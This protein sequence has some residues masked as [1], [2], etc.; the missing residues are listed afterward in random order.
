MYCP[1]C[2][3]QN[4]DGSQFCSN[5]GETT[6]FQGSQ[7]HGAHKRT[8]RSSR[9]RMLF[10]I[11][12]IALVILA[13]PMILLLNSISGSSS[14]SSASTLR[15]VTEIPDP[16]HFFG[17]DC[18]VQE[19]S[20]DNGTI[21]YTITSDEDHIQILNAYLDLLTGDYPFRKTDSEHVTKTYVQINPEDLYDYL[22][23]L[24][25][26]GSEKL[27]Y[28][29]GLQDLEYG[30]GYDIY[31]RHRG[32]GTRYTDG[33][34]VEWDE[35]T[36]IITIRNASQFEVVYDD[37]YTPPATLPPSDSPSNGPG[38][39]SPDPNND[40]KYGSALTC[41][42]CGGD[43]D[44]NSCGGAIGG[45]PSCYLSGNCQQCKGTGKRYP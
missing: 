41:T 21:V 9:K 30:H 39:P 6:G 38:V 2:G 18:K 31:I 20:D 43:G 14:K 8:R 26:K 1:K 10:L 36:T 45:C 11:I 37:T 35:S 34:T 40:V 28:D 3:Y 29:G 22:Y 19:Y 13:V 32:T 7:H 15:T 17:L 4:P 16:E 25:Y 27:G 5:C 42:T 24:E 12:P 44:C 23:G 33:Q